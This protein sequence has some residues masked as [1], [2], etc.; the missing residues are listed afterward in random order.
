MLRSFYRSLFLISISLFCSLPSLA[1]E[2]Q[3][4]P[5]FE[6]PC[7]QLPLSRLPAELNKLVPHELLVAENRCLFD[8]V[9]ITPSALPNWLEIITPKHVRTVFAFVNTQ[10]QQQAN[11]SSNCHWQNWSQK[12]ESKESVEKMGFLCTN[13]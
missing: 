5:D 2:P 3:L 4:E 10:S 8:N 6:G 11:L 13:Q 9:S 12:I 7:N 1:Q